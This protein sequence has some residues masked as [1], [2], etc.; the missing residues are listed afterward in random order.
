MA[1]SDFRSTGR[2]ES[3]WCR[4]SIQSVLLTKIYLPNVAI[5]Y[6]AGRTKL[7]LRIPEPGG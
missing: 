5:M 7:R 3:E 4:K 6:L 2:E 1:A